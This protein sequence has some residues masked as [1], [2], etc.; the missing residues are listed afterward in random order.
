MRSTEMETIQEWAIVLNAFIIGCG[1]IA[2]INDQIGYMVYGHA[3]AYYKNPH[4][5]LSAC[6]DTNINK[7]KSLA[8]QFGGSAFSNY[9]EALEKCHRPNIVSICSPDE[10]HYQHALEVL[11]EKIRPDI[12]FLEKPACKNEDELTNLINL[13]KELHV[14]IIINHSRRF[15][16]KL[17]QLS[18]LIHQ[19]YFG[20]LVRGDIFYY[21]GWLHNGIHVIDTLALLFNECPTVISKTGVMKSPYQNDPTYDLILRLQNGARIHLHAMNEDHY[22]IFDFDLKFDRSRLRI[23]DFGSKILYE[24]KVINRQDEN[25]LVPQELMLQADDTSRMENAI[26]SLAEA[27]LA[28]DGNFLLNNASILNISKVMNTLWSVQLETINLTKSHLAINGGK[29]LRSKPW[30]DNFTTGEEEK[31]AALRVLDSGYLSLFEGSHTPEL[32]FSFYG[33]PEV[34]K[35]EEMWCKYYNSQYAVSVN[36]ATSGLYMAIGALGVGYGDEVIVSPY[37]MSASATAPLVYGAI[38]VFAD[39]DRATGS[40][41]PISVKSKISE[42]T[43]AIIVVHQFGIPCDMDPII[44]LARKNNIKVIEDCAQAHGAKYK[45][46]SIGTI[47]DIG[48]FSLNVNKTI[49]T[50]EGGICTTN[51]H[52]L[53][54]RLALIR[55][56][57]E[58]V[59]GPAQYDDILNILGFNYR[60]TELQAAIAQEQLKKLEILNLRRIEMVEQ[61]NEGLRPYAFLRTPPHFQDRTST[62]YVYPLRFDAQKA[63]ISRTQFNK[64]LKSEGIIFAEGYVRPLYY[65][66]LYQKQLLFKS[67]MPFQAEQNRACKKD[68]HPG[69]C[70]VAEKLHFEEM[71]INEYVRPP[72]TCADIKDIIEGFKKIIA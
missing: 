59:V 42:R 35:L 65:Q 6:I 26:D 10:F 38:P 4:T 32:P 37:T 62:F 48:I 46:R 25:V 33:G 45:G 20:T 19:N 14:E 58:A 22:Q 18:A 31:A 39:V 40:L 16:K 51:N 72:H 55:N 3:H 52:E 56:H 34:Q 17:L 41:D 50:G 69:L 11:N 61:L 53:R 8:N 36:S 30:L 13:S 60:L 7:A 15:D 68:Y 12:I 44:D 67:G 29:A 64:A 47:G 54:Y 43:R 63:G 71:L 57:G 2:G 9:H 28:K 5:Q 70:P 24:K 27:V 66:P 1:K 23:E 21:S 49:Q